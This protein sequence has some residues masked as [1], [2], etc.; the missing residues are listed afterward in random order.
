MKLF[1]KRIFRLLIYLACAYLFLMLPFPESGKAPAASSSSV[2]AWNRDSLWSG[3]ESEFR[4]ARV[5]PADQIE[6]LIDSVKI[7]IDSSLVPLLVSGLSP[8]DPVIANIRDQYFRLA[9][10]IAANPSR[11]DWYTNVYVETRR[12]LKAFALYWNVPDQ[13]TR[14]VLY[15]ILYGMRAALEE[16]SLQMPD[17]LVNRACYYNPVYAETDSTIWNNMVFHSGD[18]FLSRGGADVSAFI[19]RGNDFPGNFSHVALLRIDPVTKVPMMIEAH[20]E[21]GVSVSTIHEYLHDKKLRIMVLRVNPNFSTM[22]ENRDLPQRAADNIYN[23]FKK[24]HI[25][26]DFAMDYADSTSMFCSEVVSFAYRK[27]GLPL[28]KLMSTISSPGMVRWLHDFGV[29]HFLTQMPSDLE[30]DP[31]LSVVAE[32]KD[33]EML[34]SEHIDNAVMDYLYEQANLGKRIGYN[35]WKLPVAR[36]VKAYCAILNTMGKTGLIPEGMNATRALRNERFASMF[37]AVKVK[38]RAGANDFQHEH[39]YRPPYWRLL[40]LARGK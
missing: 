8:T 32:W 23:E 15:T 2:F 6:R 20:I 30:Y 34:F 22:Q 16:V 36:A 29:K 28:W 14:E 35:V 21:K 31:S 38:V 17:S 25:P 37:A 13:H 18:I 40:D 4:K 9:P 27:S 19:S 11:Y 12:K 39:G 5:I 3:L 24:R 33:V 1:H 7:N 10:Y 26:Y